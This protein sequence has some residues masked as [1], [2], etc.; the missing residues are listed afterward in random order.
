MK[1]RSGVST[2]LPTCRSQGDDRSVRRQRLVGGKR[3]AGDLYSRD[4]V[5]VIG[6]PSDTY[7]RGISDFGNGPPGA[8]AHAPGPV[9]GMAG[10][11]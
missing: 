5:S 6:N 9:R 11:F 2:A 10:C 4:S 8:G 1:K 7:D 3:H